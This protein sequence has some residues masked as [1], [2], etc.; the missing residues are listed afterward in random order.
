MACIYV[1]HH[2]LFAIGKDEPG[3]MNRGVI[4]GS[5][6]EHLRSECHMIRLELDEH[7]RLQVA[8]IDNCIAA[9]GQSCPDGDLCLNS[10]E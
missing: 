5:L 6:V 7:E 10:N 2:R 9:L 8:R 1:C 3:R 4:Y